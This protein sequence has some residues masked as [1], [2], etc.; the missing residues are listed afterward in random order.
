MV[1]VPCASVVVLRDWFVAVQ[2]AVTVAPG[3]TPPVPSVI[4][5]LTSPVV[6]CANDGSGRAESTANVRQ[7]TQRRCDMKRRPLVFARGTAT[8]KV[9]AFVNRDRALVNNEHVPDS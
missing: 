2:T 6:R 5:P 3:R 9:S 1:N 8:R 4:E 7:T